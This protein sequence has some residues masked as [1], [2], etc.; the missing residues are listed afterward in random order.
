MIFYG[1]DEHIVRPREPFIH[2]DT[3]V[4]SEY[5]SV[6]TLECDWNEFKALLMEIDSDTPT[7]TIDTY[8]EPI[9]LTGYST[10]NWVKLCIERKVNNG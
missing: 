2:I 4:T 5:P 7:V 1:K 3:E 9:Q 10:D 6:K 8:R